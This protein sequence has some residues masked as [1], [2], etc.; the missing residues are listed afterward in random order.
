M[1]TK[2]YFNYLFSHAV[3]GCVGV[4][5][6]KEKIP[7]SVHNPKPILQASVNWSDLQ[8]EWKGPTELLGVIIPAVFME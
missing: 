1:A 7:W 6:A 8:K 3:F 4:P 2:T 5:A